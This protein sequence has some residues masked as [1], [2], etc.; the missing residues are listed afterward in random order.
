MG[1]LSC[2]Y[3]QAL[4][5]WDSLNLTAGVIVLYFISKKVDFGYFLAKRGNFMSISSDFVQMSSKRGEIWQIFASK[6]VWVSKLGRFLAT[7]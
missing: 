3:L 6:T 4:R 5:K 2:V 7:K 1:R